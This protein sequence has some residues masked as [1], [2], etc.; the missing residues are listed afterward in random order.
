[1]KYTEPFQTVEPQVFIDKIIELD[2]YSMSLSQEFDRRGATLLNASQV[3]WKTEDDNYIYKAMGTGPFQRLKAT[4]DFISLFNFSCFEPFEIIYEGQIIVIIKQKKLKKIELLDNANLMVPIVEQEIKK[5]YPDID[6]YPFHNLSP[7]Q[8]RFY[9]DYPEEFYVLMKFI[10]TFEIGD[11]I[12]YS[13]CGL[14]E[15]G[16]IKCFDVDIQRRCSVNKL[17]MFINKFSK[18]KYQIPYFLNLI[19]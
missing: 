11:C 12:E 2:N 10:E 3:K 18:E 1:M 13:N 19:S 17:Q 16:K 9:I 5:K 15:N 4:Q 7:Y 6:F 8:M 14:D